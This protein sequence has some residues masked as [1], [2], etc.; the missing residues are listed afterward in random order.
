[1]NMSM[2]SEKKLKLLKESCTFKNNSLIINSSEEEIQEPSSMPFNLKPI[3]RERNINEF[4]KDK[5]NQGFKGY[6]P[7]GMGIMKPSKYGLPPKRPLNIVDDPIM[8]YNEG[9]R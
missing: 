7:S 8:A 3:V 1:M 9:R 5:S 4:K 6:T 2:D